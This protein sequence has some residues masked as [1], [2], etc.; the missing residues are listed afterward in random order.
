MTALDGK[1]ALVT[2]GARVIGR[3]IALALARTGADVA[4]AD[5]DRIHGGA[6]QYG[7]E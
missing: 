3:G 5:V 4:L 7:E 1:V 6:Q 2:G